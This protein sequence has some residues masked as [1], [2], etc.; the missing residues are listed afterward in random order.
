MA[1]AVAA[2]VGLLAST[3]SSRVG[4]SRRAGGRGTAFALGEALARKAIDLAKGGDLA[5]LRM[6]M[7]RLLPARKHEP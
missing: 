7:D 3:F 4:V 2:W 6:C 1:A 5:A